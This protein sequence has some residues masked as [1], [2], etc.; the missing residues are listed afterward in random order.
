MS[1]NKLF[2]GLIILALV[3]LTSSMKAWSQQSGSVSFGDSAEITMPAPANLVA[4]TVLTADLAITGEAT[5]TLTNVDTGQSESISAGSDGGSISMEIVFDSLGL[6]PGSYMI[7][8]VFVGTVVGT[9]PFI[10]FE[11]L[12]LN[13]EFDSWETYIPNGATITL[14]ASTS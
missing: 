3:I 5:I 11:P 6:P 8:E 7:E 12:E 2:V 4:G 1:R 14:N 10:S 13:A 9:S